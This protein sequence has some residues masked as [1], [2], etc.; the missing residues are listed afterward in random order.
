ML[1]AIVS[2]SE[3]EVENEERNRHFIRF[4]KIYTII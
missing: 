2:Q 1:S 4:V 3:D